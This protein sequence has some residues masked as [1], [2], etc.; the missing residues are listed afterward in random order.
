M[1]QRDGVHLRQHGGALGARVWEQ[2]LEADGRAEA[3]ADDGEEELD[4]AHEVVEQALALG[5]HLVHE[6]VK[7][8]LVPLDEV[9]ERLDRLLRVGLAHCEVKRKRRSA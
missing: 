3:L 5:V 7:G 6:V 2:K 9:D 4:P 8:L 1:V